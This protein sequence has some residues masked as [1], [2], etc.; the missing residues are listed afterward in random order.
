MEVYDD[1][2]GDAS[3]ANQALGSINQ[4]EED[5]G[6]HNK[7]NLGGDDNDTNKESSADH[8]T[9]NSNPA[10]T[11][12]PPSIKEDAELP[13]ITV[14]YYKNMIGSPTTACKV[15]AWKPKTRMRG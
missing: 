7:S 1:D 2:T 14:N 6:P 13:I 12:P 8:E 15:V 10:K 4:A 3:P 9:N 11:S 5:K